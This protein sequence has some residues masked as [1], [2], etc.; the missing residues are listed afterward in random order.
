MDDV[1]YEGTGSGWS[2][3]V[4]LAVS[5]VVAA[6][7]LG[8]IF[9]PAI[10]PGLPMFFQLKLGAVVVG[11]LLLIVVLGWVTRK[12]EQLRRRTTEK[13]EED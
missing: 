4:V 8:L 6:A 7:L 1:M 2:D 11:G 3:F 10:N 9:A 12:I 5:A 13:E